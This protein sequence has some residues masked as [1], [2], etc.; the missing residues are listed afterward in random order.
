MRSSSF[1]EETTKLESPIDGMYLLH[2]AFKGEGHILAKT[3]DQ[4]AFGSSLQLVR[5]TF[6]R[7]GS[8]LA[9]HAQVEDEHMTFGM[10]DE[11]LV[12]LNE[13]GHKK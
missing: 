8:G 9:Y 3:L 11:K 2:K 1:Y 7:W 13:A 6:D 12:A 5:T 10:R 4:M